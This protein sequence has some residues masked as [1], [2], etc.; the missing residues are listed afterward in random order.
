MIR[1]VGTYGIAEYVAASFTD[2]L[3]LI[4]DAPV[5]DDDP[6][7]DPLAPPPRRW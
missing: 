4:A 7:F 3:K 6:D 5:F 2:F 1:V